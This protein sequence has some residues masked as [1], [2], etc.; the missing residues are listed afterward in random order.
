M[1]ER[2]ICHGCGQRIEVPDD[3]RRNKIQ[4]P[5]CGVISPVVPAA[6]K[7]AEASTGRGDAPAPAAT[8]PALADGIVAEPQSEA[9]GGTTVWTCR[10][11]GEWQPERPR[12]K[13]ARCPVCKTL[14]DPAPA[15]RPTAAARPKPRAMRPAVA[16]K[17]F[18]EDDDGKPYKVDALEAPPCPGCNKPMAPEA[19][20]CLH[21]G[22]DLRTNA[23]AETVYEP[24]KRR[25]DSGL[26]LP[27]RWLCFFAWQVVAVPPLVWGIAQ[28]GHAFWAIF[29]W[30][31]L[32]LMVAF[33]FGTFDRL[34]L[35]RNSK[36]QV[37]LVKTLHICFR[38]LPST[39]IE[40]RDYEGIQTGQIRD[41]DFTDYVVMAAGIGMGLLPGLIWYLTVM[42]RDT[43]FVALAKD[44]GHPEVM[45]YRGWNEARMKEVASALRTALLPLYT[46][47]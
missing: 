11:C 14:V 3:Y 15:S 40:P 4:C 8:E 25:W 19:L 2:V 43:F 46:W 6:R 24:M 17:E 47:Y 22:F 39:R 38:A 23:K 31:W 1:N 5:E 44:H 21:C 9:L 10:H 36:G 18:S 37:R 16:Q 28:E 34:D 41:V 35:E 33:L 13:K 27:R 45:V 7:P 20:V 32:S 12:G 26:P 42:Q 29:C 30:F